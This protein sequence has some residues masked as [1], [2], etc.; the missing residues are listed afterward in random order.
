MSGMD[1][2]MISATYSGSCCYGNSP[3]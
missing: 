1:Q 2:G 3:W